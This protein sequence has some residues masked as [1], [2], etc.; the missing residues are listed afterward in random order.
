MFLSLNAHDLQA[1]QYLAPKVFVSQSLGEGASVKALWLTASLREELKKKF[2][3]ETLAEALPGA[4][5]RYW[6]S[7]QGR[8]WVLN[9][10]G[11]DKPITVGIHIKGGQISALRILEFRESR[12][13]EVKY[14]RFTS[15]FD[16]L[17]LND[18]ERLAWSIDNVTGATL[19]VKAVKR[20]ARLAL[21]LDKSLGKTLDKKT[22]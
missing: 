12:G 18:K 14:P 17:G 19:S 10:I 21:F 13:Y 2:R 16:Q 3:P 1:K 22:E 8:V 4:R 11:R 15:Q 6:Q 7:E 20:V 9:K 5:M